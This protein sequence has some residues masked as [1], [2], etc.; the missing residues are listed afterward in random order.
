MSGG[1]F[2]GPRYTRQACLTSTVHTASRASSF[3]TWSSNTV[4]IWVRKRVRGRRVRGA[5]DRAHLAHLLALLGFA[6]RG[7]ALAELVE[8]FR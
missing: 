3:V 4:L 2:A 1:G 7:E 5:E 8:C 6:E